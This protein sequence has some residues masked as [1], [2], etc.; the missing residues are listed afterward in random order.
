LSWEKDH[1]SL[2][3]EADLFSLLG[4]VMSRVSRQ[5]YALVSRRSDLQGLDRPNSRKNSLN[6][7]LGK[8][9]SK[10]ENGLLKMAIANPARHLHKGERAAHAPRPKRRPKGWSRDRRARQAEL[11]RNWQPWKHS[12]GPKTD[13]GKARCSANALKHGRTGRAHRDRRR[14]VRYACK[15]ARHVLRLA[16]DNLRNYKAFVRRPACGP[17]K[18]KLRKKNRPLQLALRFPRSFTGRPVGQPVSRN[19]GRSGEENAPRTSNTGT[20]SLLTRTASGL[21][22]QG[23]KSG[24]FHAR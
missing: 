19:S 18:F 15:L 9:F 8:K 13:G 12:T 10:R 23:S 11:I 1:D 5:S 7:S 22:F 2:T 6:Q 24:L 4:A 20:S 21:P 16:A 14:A 3:K 17:I